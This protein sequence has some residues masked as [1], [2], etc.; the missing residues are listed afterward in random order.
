MSLKMGDYVVYPAHGVGCVEAV[1]RK[2]VDNQEYEFLVIRIVE[3]DMKIM[4][5]V[6]NL[7]AVGLRPLMDAELVESLY[8]LFRNPSK[9]SDNINWNRRQRDYLERIKKGEPTELA[10]IL[11]ELLTMRQVKELS[12]GERKLLDMVK[13]ILFKEMAIAS[14]RQV[15]D[16]ENEIVSLFPISPR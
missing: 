15:K 13:G 1:E 4:V 2:N 3:N 9:S 7:D 16:V 5:P 6:Q 14:D 8:E 12:F 11:A 10:Q